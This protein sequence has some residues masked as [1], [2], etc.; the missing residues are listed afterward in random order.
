[1]A[2]EE[3]GRLAPQN[4]HFIGSWMPG[5]FVD[6]RGRSCEEPVTRRSREGEA[7]GSKVKRPSASQS[8]SRGWPAF[9]RG[10]L[11][12]PIHRWAGQAVSPG[13]EQR[14]FRLQSSS[15]QD[16]PGKPLSMVII[17][18]ASQRNSFQHGVS[19][20]FLPAALSE[21]P[22]RGP[23]DLPDLSGR[24]CSRSG[25]VPC[26]FPGQRCLFLSVLS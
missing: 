21:L 16:P 19:V 3:D 13:A 25:H 6:Q 4:N 20:G 12:S 23:L 17:M 9:R 15:V 22:S 11:I 2:D 7:V 18:R 24:S 1:M 8:I 26:P 14:H 5:S 10:V